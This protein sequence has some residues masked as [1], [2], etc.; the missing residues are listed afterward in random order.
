MRRP[1]RADRVELDGTGRG[2]QLTLNRSRTVNY[3]VKVPRS[4]NVTVRTVNGEVDVRGV[5]GL[6]RVEAVSG[7]ITGT[8]LGGGADLNSVN[9]RM[10][11]E[12][13]KLGDSGV[14][15]KTTNGQIAV[16]IPSTARATITARVINGIIQTENL[17][18]QA[19]EQSP[20]RLDA[21]IGGGG[22]EIRLETV[23]GEV[24]ITGK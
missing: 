5:E 11:L 7:L 3:D 4:V 13:V 19:A 2:F 14:R 22:T 24:R 21:T 12:F 16:T 1:R 6:L 23:N 15:C 17:T 9:G 8:G 18:L 20:R 10:T